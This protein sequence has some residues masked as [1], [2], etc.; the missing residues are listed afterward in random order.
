MASIAHLHIT[1][2]FLLVKCVSSQQQKHFFVM[3]GAL[4]W[5]VGALI[6]AVGALIWAVGALIWAVGA[7]I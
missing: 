3:V 2:L 5:A 6:W 4:I 1:W 7:L